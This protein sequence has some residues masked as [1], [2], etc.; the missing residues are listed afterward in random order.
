MIRTAW[1]CQCSD[2]IHYSP[3]E[4]TTSVVLITSV[5]PVEKE[6]ISSNHWLFF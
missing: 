2:L 3:S 5:Q 1:N 6:W 4:A